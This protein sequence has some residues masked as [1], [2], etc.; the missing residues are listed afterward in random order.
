VQLDWFHV[1]NFKSYL[2]SGRLPLTSGM[3]VVV[4]RNS[5]GKSALLD[6]LGLRFMGRPHR[7]LKSLPHPG[8][9]E[10]P[11]SRVHLQARCPGPELKRTFLQSNSQYYFPWP[12]GTTQSESNARP[13]IERLFSAEVVSCKLEALASKDSVASI[14]AGSRFALFWDGAPNDGG[15]D[16]LNVL[17]QPTPD[18]R[19]V[20]QIHFGNGGG[21][22]AQLM[23]ATLLPR[24]FRFQA[25][26]MSIGLCQAG[27]NTV[28]KPDASNLPEVL[29]N[30][31]GNPALFDDY[32]RAIREVFP[33]AKAITTRPASNNR[34]EV[35]VWQISPA[36]RRHDLAFSLNEC[37]TGIGQVLAI[38]YV[39]MAS[40]EPQ[41]ILIDEPNSFLHPGAARALI[42]VLRQFP[43]HQYVI[44]THAPEIIAEAGHC[45]IIR[46]Q[47][48]EGASE[49]QLYPKRDTE[50]SRKLL[51][52][53]G[54]R[55]SDVFGF[56]EVLWVEGLSDQACI[57]TIL[58]SLFEPRSGLAVLAVRDTGNFDRRRAADIVAIYRQASLASAVVPPTVGFLL[59]RD[60]R[61]DRDMKEIVRETNGAVSFLDR[62]MLENYLL[63]PG[64][65][66]KVLNTEWHGAYDITTEKVKNWL[67]ANG[68]APEFGARACTAFSD[69][70]LQKVDGAK[71]L[72]ALFA[73][74]AEQP[75]EFRKTTHC[76]QLVRAIIEGDAN[77]LAPLINLI[78]GKLGAK[79]RNAADRSSAAA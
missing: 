43:H 75:A 16:S 78:E 56:D 35:F 6:A 2:D 27:T 1:S 69:E 15:A 71:L 73:G 29:S 33:L 36:S 51:I 40:P 53:V 22:P 54:A 20:G 30:L 3:T 44:A 62:L 68:T 77:T 67:L 11:V 79:R 25:E 37:G 9:A 65:I 21:S 64:A 39:V 57:K 7:S 17:I 24:L 70:W 5:A 47:W 72:R 8:D 45:P 55:L 48:A 49:C 63:D 13:F 26:R 50:M 14:D 18:K 41:T 60:G 61:N 34:V 59:D 58:E 76:E 28:L 4:G 38:L 19:N 52:D 46:V 74:I 12:K 66:A 10:D 31:Q 32:E 23:A 42:R